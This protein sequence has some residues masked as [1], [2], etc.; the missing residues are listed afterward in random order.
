MKDNIKIS[1]KIE[2]YTI[3]ELSS[4]VTLHV[5]VGLAS[6]I[7][8]RGVILG[9]FIPF[10]LAFLGGCSSY[11]VPAAMVGAFISYFI[12]AAD[13]SGFRYI[14]AL[15]AVLSIKLLLSNYK[16]IVIST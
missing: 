6:A 11:F 1:A 9:Q 14:A 3:K 13:T 2:D 12:P 15:F 16:K 10:G 7:M 4:A 5:L 8:S